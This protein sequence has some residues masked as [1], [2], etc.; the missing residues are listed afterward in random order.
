[1]KDLLRIDQKA[2]LNLRVPPLVY[3]SSL[4]YCRKRQIFYQYN[5]DKLRDG[6]EVAWRDKSVDKRAK[7]I[8]EV[9]VLFVI[10]LIF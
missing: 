5:L 10:T 2:Y 7:A 1:M 8:R 3:L 4:I 9:Y 6:K